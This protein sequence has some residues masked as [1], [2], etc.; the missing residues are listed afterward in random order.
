[1][2]VARGAEERAGAFEAL[3][4]PTRVVGEAGRVVGAG[5]RA[6]HDLGEP[7]HEVPGELHPKVS[8]KGVVA[9]PCAALALQEALGGIVGRDRVADPRD[10]LGTRSTSLRALRETGAAAAPTKLK[11]GW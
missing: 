2:G 5:G 7:G 3:D 9:N 6:R 4:Q 8:T 10:T 1:M 11:S